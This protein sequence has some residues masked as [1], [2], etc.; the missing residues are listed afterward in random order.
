MLFST[1]QFT[2]RWAPQG[3]NWIQTDIVN[4]SQ[5]DLQCLQS[6]KKTR[7]LHLNL[8][9][10]G[11]NCTHLKRK[12]NKFFQVFCKSDAVFNHPLSMQR[13]A[14]ALG[15]RFFCFFMLSS[16][17]ANNWYIVVRY[18]SNDSFDWKTYRPIVIDSYRP[19]HYTVRPYQWHHYC[20]W[21]S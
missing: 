20:W 1:P 3:K 5:R 11:Y 10:I 21:Q 7:H 14:R 15:Y 16:T 12:F 19:P 8:S 2:H 18:C 17:H 4:L 6:D 13:L 9:A